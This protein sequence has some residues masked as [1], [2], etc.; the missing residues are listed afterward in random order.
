LFI[1]LPYTS[2]LYRLNPLERLS[3]PLTY[4]K[5]QYEYSV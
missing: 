1:R 5:R 3:Q 2:Y 4:R